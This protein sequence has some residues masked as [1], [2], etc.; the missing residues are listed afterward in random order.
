MIGNQND[1][2]R[3]RIITLEAE[4]EA[5]RKEVDRYSFGWAKTADT[6]NQELRENGPVDVGQYVRVEDTANGVRYLVDIM[7]KKIVKAESSLALAIE[8]AEKAEALK[9]CEAH[10]ENQIC[11]WEPLARKHWDALALATD[12][13]KKFTDKWETTLSTLRETEDARKEAES[14]NKRLRDELRASGCFKC[15][16]VLNLYEKELK[17]FALQAGSG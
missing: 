13:V 15:R 4:L 7:R 14:E 2:M 3:A 11:G 5:A 1:L 9:S 10:T 8:R 6:L 17:P 16:S 12:E